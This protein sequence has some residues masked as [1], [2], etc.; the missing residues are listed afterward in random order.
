MKHLVT[1]ADAHVPALVHMVGER[2][3]YRFFEFFIANI[4]ACIRAAPMRARRT[5]Y[6]IS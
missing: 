4:R 3:S 6:W 2:A 1:A 5:N